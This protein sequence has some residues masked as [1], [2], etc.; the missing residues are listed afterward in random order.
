[1]P[2]S[3]FNHEPFLKMQRPN[4]NQ[5]LTMNHFQ[6]KIKIGSKS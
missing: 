2:R 1:M 4:N 6:I 5:I 3:N